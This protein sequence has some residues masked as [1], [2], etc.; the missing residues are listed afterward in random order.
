MTGPACTRIDEVGVL[1]VCLADCKQA[2]TL[3][4]GGVRLR[5]K[6]RLRARPQDV[7]R[8]TESS[9][10]LA[11][12]RESQELFTGLST[13][14][15]ESLSRGPACKDSTAVFVIPICSASI[16]CKEISCG[17]FPSSL[18]DG[19]PCCTLKTRSGLKCRAM[20][21]NRR[22]RGVISQ[23]QFPSP[24]FESSEMS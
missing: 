21:E 14:S 4:P 6:G 17:R 9:W 19:G 20:L 16:D 10:Q 12:F 22:W 11:D 2:A 5:E 23:L 8:R 18:K 3:T 24:R 15:L 13:L 7:N 1:P